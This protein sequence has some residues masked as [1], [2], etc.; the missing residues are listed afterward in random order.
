[1]RAIFLSLLIEPMGAGGA[2]KNC[3]E[4]FATVI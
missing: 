3:L 1:M 4:I 2:K